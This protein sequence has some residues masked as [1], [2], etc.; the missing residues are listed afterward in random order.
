M[1]KEFNCL[2][3]PAIYLPENSQRECCL[4][5]IR[6]K[7]VP[8]RARALPPESEK[9]FAMTLVGQTIKKNQPRTSQISLLVYIE[10]YYCNVKSHLI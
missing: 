5:V 4:T 7:P 10:P 3:I 8:K 2:G 1:W 6:K 9:S